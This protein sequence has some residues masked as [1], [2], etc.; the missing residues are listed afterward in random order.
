MENKNEY[1]FGMHPVKEALEAGKKI[2][3]VMFRQGLDGVQFHS[4]LK[5]LQEAD[6]EK[7]E[8]LK[9]ARKKELEFLQKEQALK[10]KEEELELSLQ[11]QLIEE[12]EKLKEQNV[13]RFERTLL[14][15][16]RTS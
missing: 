16:L 7:E 12:R 4:L 5:M 6:K 1:L 13:N 10:T 8:K 2:E 15:I 3:K 9:E 11:R 14:L